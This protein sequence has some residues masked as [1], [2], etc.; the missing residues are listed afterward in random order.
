[1]SAWPHFIVAVLINSLWQAP[2]VLL[3]TWLC[4][5]MAAKSTASTRYLAWSIALAAAT[6]LPFVTANVQ[7]A[8]V[9]RSV[10]TP[11]VSA[12]SHAEHAR[13]SPAT[14]PSQSR[15]VFSM[16]RPR[17][18]LAT[19]L[20]ITIAIVWGAIAALLLLRLLIELVRLERFKR[21]ALPLPFEY[22][23]ALARWTA[24]AGHRSDARVCVSPHTDVPVAVGLFDAMILLPQDLLNALRPIE[25]E[26]IALHEL[27][28]LRRHDDWVNALERLAVTLFFFNPAVRWIAAQMDLE[29]EVACDDYVVQLTHEVRPYAH[30]LTKMAEATQWPRNALAAPGVFVTR[31]S[32]SIRIERLLRAGSSGRLKISYSTALAALAAMALLFVGSEIA[33]PV[34]AAALGAPQQHSIAQRPAPKRPLRKIARVTPAPVPPSKTL[35]VAAAP[36]IT[37]SP[38]A[39]ATH[40][41]AP[42]HPARTPKATSHKPPAR[43]A[44]SP[45]IPPEVLRRCDG[46]D[47]AGVDWRGRDLRG[48]QLHGANL[49]DA[50]LRGADLRDADLSGSNLQ[51]ARLDGA[52]LQGTKLS[53]IAISGNLIRN[54]DLSQVQLAGDSVD[55]AGLDLATLR[56][57]LNSCAGC[58]FNGLDVRG[59]DLSGLRIVGIDLA[60]VDFRGTDLRNTTFA[61]VNFEHAHFQGA[62]LDG[63][64]FAGCNLAGVDF[65]GVDVSG[66]KF[67][68]SNLSDTIM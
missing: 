19:P 49:S 65:R 29:R 47:F 62:K 23:E 15:P 34:F 41:V 21:D 68:G 46:C 18:T 39:L 48:I 52:K 33:G 63:A 51:G 57:L 44:T 27:G 1:M 40:A 66:A 67:A 42:P 26:H 31:K 17:I 14:A 13:V 36:I 50:D 56:T 43:T 3:L 45:R 60:N 7:I 8:S 22:R 6:V 58:S 61:G 12:P 16:Q 53:G 9:H 5:R 64:S 24:A 28:H 20:S 30:C 54:V 25:L 2:L 32:M 38:V 10:S 59:K 37:A 55:A 4:L 11:A 35:V